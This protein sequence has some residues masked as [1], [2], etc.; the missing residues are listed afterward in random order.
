MPSAWQAFDTV[1]R[2]AN[3]DWAHAQCLACERRWTW[4]RRALGWHG[5]KL[6]LYRVL[7]PACL[8]PLRYCRLQTGFR[9]IPHALV[10]AYTRDWPGP[11]P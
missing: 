8:G 11:R 3:Y 4:H 2:P 10:R 9:V 1:V 7:C 5:V 6:P